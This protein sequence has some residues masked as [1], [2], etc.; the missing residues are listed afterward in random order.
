MALSYCTSQHNTTISL[1]FPGGISGYVLQYCVLDDSSASWCW[2]LPPLPVSGNL[3]FLCGPKS[4]SADWC[5]FQFP[6]GRLTFFKQLTSATY[7]RCRCQSCL[8]ASLTDVFPVGGN[9]C[10][11]CHSNSGP[12]VFG[13][14]C[15]FWYHS[16]VPAVDVIHILCQVG[17]LFTFTF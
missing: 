11:P 16:L 5:R 15:Q 8:L 17:A 4:G 6:A 13:L 10:R 1:C 14:L 12:A 3:D 9:I 7:R 2:T